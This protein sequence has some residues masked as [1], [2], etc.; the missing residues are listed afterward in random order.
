MVFLSALLIAVIIVWATMTI[1]REVRLSRGRA[2]EDRAAAW[3]ATFAPG[4]AASQDDPRALLTWQPLA[5]AARRLDPDAFVEL[6]LALHLRSSRGVLGGL[7]IDDAA[8][9]GNLLVASNRSDDLDAFADLITKPDTCRRTKLVRRRRPV[10]LSRGG[11]NER[12][13]H[14]ALTQ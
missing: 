8:G 7:L 6:G 11:Q 1:A 4:M 10:L 14:P 2:L 13:R 12:I 9:R 5:A 3:L